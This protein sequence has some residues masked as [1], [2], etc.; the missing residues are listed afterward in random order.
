[1][2]DIDGAGTEPTYHPFALTGLVGGL[3]VPRLPELSVCIGA[4]PAWQG[5]PYLQ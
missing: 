1:M 2:E 5:V 4:G 3:P